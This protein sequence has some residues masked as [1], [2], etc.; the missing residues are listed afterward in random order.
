MH[1]HTSYSIS[2]HLLTFEVQVVHGEKGMV[3]DVVDAVLQ[4]AQAKSSIGVEE[5]S[6]WGG[7]LMCV[8]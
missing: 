2:A 6:V 5:S 7:G 1:T 8:H 4:G 3:L